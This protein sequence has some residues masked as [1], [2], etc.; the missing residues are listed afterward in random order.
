MPI[1]YF[2]AQPTRL[3][4]FLEPTHYIHTDYFKLSLRFFSVLGG[5]E[6][7]SILRPSFPIFEMEL[8]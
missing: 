8:F 7:L 6:N 5:F 2:D 4:D 1:Q 3:C